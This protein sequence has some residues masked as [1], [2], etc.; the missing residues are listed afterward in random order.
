LRQHD[1]WENDTRSREA[2]K[3]NAKEITPAVRQYFRQKADELKAT[4]CLQPTGPGLELKK[5]DK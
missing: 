5:Y 1:Q 2:G 4:V 3:P